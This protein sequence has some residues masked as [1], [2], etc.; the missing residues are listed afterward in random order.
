MTTTIE[1]IYEQGV[2]RPL[3]PLA[4]SEGQQVQVFLATEEAVGG[5]N[6][7]S[8]LAEIAALPMETPVDASTS[9]NHDQVLYGTTDQP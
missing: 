1:A 6:T 4:L 3:T 5:Q 7:A 2:L 9:R 8:I